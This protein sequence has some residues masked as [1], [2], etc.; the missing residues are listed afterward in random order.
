[1]TRG[2]VYLQVAIGRDVDAFL[3]HEAARLHMTVA[4][5]IVWHLQRYLAEETDFHYAHDVPR[6]M[7][8]RL[9]QCGL[10]DAVLAGLKKVQG[11]HSLPDERL[12][13][14]DIVMTHAVNR[15]LRRAMRPDAKS[16]TPP[17]NTQAVTQARLHRQRRQGP[18]YKL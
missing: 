15:Q 16:Q 11:A 12:R 17:R 4:E 7:R 1:M 6:D 8:V 2:P 14:L 9:V 13:S 18:N 5:C 3:Q 10:P